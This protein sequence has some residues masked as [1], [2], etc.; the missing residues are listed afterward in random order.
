[1]NNLMLVIGLSLFGYEYAY[2]VFRKYDNLLM[3]IGHFPHGADRCL[4]QMLLPQ[5]LSA[6]PNRT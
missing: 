6:D 1:M 3:Q 2:A 5:I 4:H